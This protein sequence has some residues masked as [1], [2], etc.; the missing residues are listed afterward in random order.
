MNFGDPFWEEPEQVRE[1]AAR[2]VDHRVSAILGSVPSPSA[3]RVLDL[4]CAGGRNAVFLATMGFDLEAVDASSAMVEHTR[5]RLVPILGLEQATA[6][7]QAARMDRLDRFA[8][9][10]FDWV[11]ALG[12]YFLA[13]D[14]GEFEAAIA[15]TRRVL[16]SGGHALVANFGPGFGPID[17]P[18]EPVGGSAHL[19]MHP[20]LGRV[21]LLDAGELDLR[22]GRHGLVPEVPTE[23]VV[24]EADGTRRVTINGL[25]RLA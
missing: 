3:T 22:F 2:E 13:K 20:R 4:G 19:F 1:F 15:E 23:T 6:R 24:R 18:L 14:E 17:S 16:R 21:C 10:S 11:I 5:E 7:A 12:V 25:Y 8:S 9:G